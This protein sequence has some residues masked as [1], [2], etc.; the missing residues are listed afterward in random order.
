MLQVFRFIPEIPSLLKTIDPTTAKPGEMQKQV[1]KQLSI[2]LNN[3]PNNLANLVDIIRKSNP[4]FEKRD[5]NNN[6]IQQDASEC[7]GYLMKCIHQYAGNKISDLF[8]I[9]F[10]TKTK[11]LGS[12]EQPVIGTEDDDR[13][14]C[15]IDQ[16]TSQIEQGI[17]LD[18]KIEKINQKND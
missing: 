13:L 17:K 15:F 4:D 6:F 10:E 9:Q 1:A 14:R 12:E 5:Q 11:P 8:H 16:D 18:S 7:W 3:F 2:F